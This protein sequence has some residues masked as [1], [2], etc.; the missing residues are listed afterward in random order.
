MSQPAIPR[1]CRLTLLLSLPWPGAIACAQAVANSASPASPTNDP[2]EAIAAEVVTLTPFTVTSTQ[3]RGY[4][5]QS[6]LGG[7]R[8][9]TNLKDVAAPTSAFTAE[10]LND[11]GITNTDDLARYMLS[12]EYDFGENSAPGQN[13]LASSSTRSLR[14]R[15]LPGGTVAVNF[16]KSDFPADTFSTERIDQAR[17]PNS[18][19]FGIGSPGGLINVTNKR[20]LLGKNAASVAVQG[21]SEGGLR[22]EA[23]YN[24]AIGDRISLRVTAMKEQRGSW[25]NYEFSDSE[26]AYLTGKW[27]VSPKTEFNFDLEKADLNKRTVRSITAY[28][29]YT[30]WA[31][32]GRNVGAINAAQ[33]ISGVAANNTPYLVLDT[34]SGVLTNWVNKTRSTLWTAIDGENVPVSDFK[35]LPKETSVYGPG[36]GLDT[37]Y[38]RLGAYLTHAFTP[39]LNL[40]IAGMRT[41]S[42]TFNSDSQTAN[43]RAI[44]VDTNPTLPSGAVNPN[45]GKTYVEGLPQIGFGDTR[46]DSVRT[47]LSYAR[48][49]GRWGK[50]TLAGVYQ[51]DF[52]KLSQ[53][54]V[55]EQIISPNAPTLTSAVNNNNRIFR[56]TYVDL[57]GPSRSIVMAPYNRQAL[58][59]ITE[60]ISGRSYTTALVPFNVNGILNSF[61][62]QTMIGMLQSS[63]WNN[64]IKTIMG[65]SRDDRNDYASTSVLM[66][67]AGFASGIPTPVRSQTPFNTVAT[68]V[69]F[70]GVL[71]ATEWLGLTY[72]QAGNSGLPS[73]GGRLNVPSA[74]VAG[75]SRPPTPKGKSQDI[76]FKLDLFKNRLFVTAQYFQTSA[77]RDF[78]FGN[79]ASSINPIWSALALAGKVP[80]GTVQ[81]GTG[82]TFDNRTQGYEVEL[83]ANPTAQW[84][85]FLN[86]SQSKSAQTNIGQ[87]DLAYIAFWRPTWEA[88]AALPLST[89]AGTIATQLA[90]L[91]VRTFTD[92]T[93]AQGRPA[94]GQM[95]HKLNFVSNYEFAQGPLKGITVG[96]GVRYTGRPI[97][98]YRA[99]GTPGAI[100]S[101]VSAGSEQVFLDLNAAYRRKLQLM[102]KSVAWSLQT[103]INNALN[104]DAFIRI[105]TAR[106]GV[107]TAYRFNPPLEWMITTK[108]SF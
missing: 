11:V 104:N 7:S 82:R 36:F 86:Y 63:F 66:P 67:V 45:V 101:T 88:N 56:R 27:R 75:F 3:D 24:Q 9:R 29:A 87:E 42:H 8:L 79:I 55:R 99:T 44:V 10:F 95:E 4:Q 28:D 58:G 6:T 81:S 53:I 92:F 108:F 93:L 34:A 77:A 39:D 106:D 38:A 31:A 90:A 97:N 15:G 102:G 91:D 57:A 50:H 25:R 107:L 54:V 83:T 46:S 98:G 80:S 74:D 21:R 78:D 23:D 72:S 32:A 12:T 33:Q 61:D 49:F 51:Y 5:A 59:T 41:D 105:N 73:F 26:R 35:L 17:G 84:R 94:L 30:R 48:D 13:F 2:K 103:N 60:T 40:E 52:T 71:Q 85:V 69:S 18:I 100:V 16:F 70:S 19:L 37:N 65:T 76:G 22:E 68:S 47:V 62:S 14:M 43:T 96:G 1:L 89:G 20:A 64:R